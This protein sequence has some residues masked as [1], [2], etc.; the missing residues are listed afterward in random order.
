MRAKELDSDILITF[1]ADGQHRI[2]DIRK[3]VTKP[4]IDQEADLVI[5]SRFL[6]ES[7]I[8]RYSTITEKLG[9]KVITKITNMS[10]IKKAINRFTKWF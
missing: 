1:D 10:S 4:I 6:D 5:G 3:V 7:E 8:R 9:I 2:E